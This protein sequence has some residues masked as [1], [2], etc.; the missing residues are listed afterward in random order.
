MLKNIIDRVATTMTNVIVVSTTITTTFLVPFF[1]YK[2]VHYFLDNNM[3]NTVM[4]LVS[5]YLLVQINKS[6]QGGH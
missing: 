4:C 1:M 2:G 6:I 5:V 3:T